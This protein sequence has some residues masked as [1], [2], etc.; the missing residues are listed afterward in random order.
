MKRALIIYAILFAITIA[1]PAIVCFGKF[2][3]SSNGELVNIF[4]QCITLFEC[5]H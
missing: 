3:G 1:V 5:Y 2:S 4:R